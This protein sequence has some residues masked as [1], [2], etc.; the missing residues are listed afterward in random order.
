MDTELT[1]KRPAL[2]PVCQPHLRTAGKDAPHL[3]PDPAF[4]SGGVQGC[5]VRTRTAPWSRGMRAV[6]TMK[7]RDFT[8]PT[9][10]EIWNRTQNCELQIK[11]G[12][13]N[14]IVDAV[15]KGIRKKRFS[16]AQTSW[17][18][19]T[20]E[21]NLWRVR[22][23]SRKELHSLNGLRSISATDVGVIPITLDGERA[24]RVIPGAMSATVVLRQRNSSRKT[25]DVRGWGVHWLQR[26]PEACRGPSFL[27]T[28]VRFCSVLCIGCMRQA[29]GPSRF[30]APGPWLSASPRTPENTSYRGQIV[31]DRSRRWPQTWSM[32]VE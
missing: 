21:E 11:S 12:S 32:L 3:T 5:V 8:I 31:E 17:R 16:R 25:R 20:L 4:G 6:R 24:E 27:I 14:P 23:D 22:E 10:L 15:Y 9:L 18:M 30:V 2:G 7:S 26:R 29:S 13:K 19:L 1:A 28:N